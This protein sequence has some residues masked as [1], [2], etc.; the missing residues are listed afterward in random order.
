MHNDLQRLW[1]LQK[2]DSAIG[3]LETDL[4]S[5]D[6]G[7]DLRA[8][9]A[10]A[11]LESAARTSRL[12][13]DAAAQSTLEAELEKTELKRSEAMAKAYGGTVSNPKEL[14]TL[15]QGIEA[16]G[17]QMD[18]VEN[19]LL[20]L[21]DK[22]D[23]EQTAVEAQEAEIARLRRGLEQTVSTHENESARLSDQIGALRTERNGAIEGLD[24]GSLS[25][26]ERILKKAGN[27]AVAAVQGGM[28]AACRVTLPTVQITRLQQGTELQQCESCLRILW[29]SGE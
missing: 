28:C 7:S 27:V 25:K 15:E 21:F 18:R 29:I 24:S 13:E 17:R 10:S 5:L 8:Q 26:Y 19:E 22:V 9:L 11:E 6:D 16:L 4:R 14:E 20:P 3:E 12:N 1:E 2:I 23:E